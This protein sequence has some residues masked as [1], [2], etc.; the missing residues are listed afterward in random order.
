M[1]IKQGIK[2]IVDTGMFALLTL[3]MGEHLLPGKIHEWLGASVFAL[4]VLH[5]VLNFKWYKNLFKGRYTAF[6]IAY[7]VITLLLLVVMLL[8]IISAVFISTTVFA[9][10]KL[11]QAYF[12]RTL[13]LTTTAWVYMLSAVHIG[14]HW[15]RF[16]I[17]GKKV[18][19]T[20]NTK[21]A[22]K[23]VICICIFSLCFYGVSVWINRAFYEELLFL[24]E[25]KYFDYNKTVIEYSWETIT[26][27]IAVA[28][29][30]YYLRKIALWSKRKNNK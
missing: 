20:S 6:R 7:T 15:Q 19:L 27:A 4:F 12:G 25:F 5:T 18:K 21:R 26:M 16:M 10:I 3:L 17:I 2:I 9:F 24:T 11:N 13:H 1:K 14:L 22:I 8:C 23:W 28:T 29:V 30:T